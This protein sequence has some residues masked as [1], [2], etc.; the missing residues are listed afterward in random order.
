MNNSFITGGSNPGWVAVDGQHIYWTN[1]SGSSIGRANLDGTS[2]DQSFISLSG[3]PGPDGVAV[4]GRHIYWTS[5]SP[6]SIG[7]A[8]LDGTAVEQELHSPPGTPTR[9]G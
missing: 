7:R 5:D 1:P 8:N 2:V 9:M 6:G 4:D 3:V